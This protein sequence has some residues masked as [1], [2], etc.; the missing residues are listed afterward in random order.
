MTEEEERPFEQCGTC[1][2][3][4][5]FPSQQIVPT[6]KILYQK[7]IFYYYFGINFHLS[8]LY[9]TLHFFIYF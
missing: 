8:P 6:T 9:L 4:K 5:I 3:Q 7:K 2:W 1:D